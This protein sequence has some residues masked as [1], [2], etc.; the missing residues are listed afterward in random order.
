MEC[1]VYRPLILVVE[2]DR[3][4]SRALSEL[5]TD[6]GY[7]VVLADDCIEAMTVLTTMRPNLVTLDL[8][9]P[10]IPGEAVL[11][12]MRESVALKDIPVIVLS[13]T[14]KI[15]D[16]VRHLAQAVIAKP[17]EMSE[18]LTLVERLV[19]RETMAIA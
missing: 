11:E 19:G 9:L 16:R 10:D 4:I 7:Q 14:T 3:V 18:L 15:P 13:A 17:Y 1:S 2:D 12:R 8:G 6:E 5:F